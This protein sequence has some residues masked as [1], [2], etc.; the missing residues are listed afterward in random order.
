MDN[1]IKP[2]NQMYQYRQPQ[3]PDGVVGLC[4]GGARTRVKC[5]DGESNESK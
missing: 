3:V 4:E 5:M 2:G 1:K